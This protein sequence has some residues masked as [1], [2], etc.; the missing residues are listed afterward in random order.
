M[1]NSLPLIGIRV[2]DLTRVWAGPVAAR[3]LA[4][5]GAEVISIVA[6]SML[7][8]VPVT[9]E[10]AKLLGTYPDNRP[11]DHPWNRN[12]MAN[13]FAR[14]KL[15]ITLDLSTD[16]GIDVF[17][18]LAA[19]SDIVL[20]NYSP[21]VMPNF[22]LSYD[23]LKQLN[24]SI[25]LCS[26]PGY[27]DNGP[28]RDY[29]S[30]G[31]NLYPFG[32]LS[33]LMGYPG[34][35]PM[36]SGNAYPDPVASFNAANAIL[37]ALF[38]RKRT[39]KGQYINLSQAEGA[40]ALIGEKVLGHAMNG[41]KPQRMANRDP[42]HAPQS[43]Y[44]C[45]GEDKWVAIAV[46]CEAEWEALGKAL[47]YP[48]W[49]IEDRF[50]DPLQ[51]LLHQDEMDELIAKWTR[52]YDHYEAMHRLQSSGVP[53]GAVVNAPELMSDPHL[54]DREFYWEIDHPEAGRHRYC[55][56]PIKLSETPAYVRLPAPCLG[57]HNEAV[58]RDILGMTEEEIQKLEADRIISKVPTGELP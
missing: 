56:F 42:V 41:K 24:P 18:R 30:F 34:E 15:G 12:S 54:N 48:D 52:Q 17:R 10:V 36:M 3:I 35:G 50:A 44:P 46:N 11:G 43:A 38:Y 22:G 25:I 27:G 20:E 40:T 39:G 37:T 1:S 23:D 58:L 5:L 49:M 2:L 29:I 7:V 8:D 26:M 4:D 19:V 16:A 57:Q 32:G 21:R 33:S 55:G 9:E 53:A 45:K 51:R 6:A 47:G 13:D 31:T 28:Y 14:N